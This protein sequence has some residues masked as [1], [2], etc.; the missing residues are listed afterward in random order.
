MKKLIILAMVFLLN[1]T[2]VNA[3]TGL[4]TSEGG[5]AFA[6]VGI[7]IVVIFFVVREFAKRFKGK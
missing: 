6:T 3:Q 7:V 4:F 5:T 1:L 2:I